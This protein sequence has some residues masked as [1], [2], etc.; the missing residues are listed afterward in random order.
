MKKQITKALMLVF[1]ASM[2]LPSYS[3]SQ[4]MR[5]WTW[6]PYKVKFKM[7]YNW[8]AKKSTG[9]VFIAKGPNDVTMKI[10]PLSY[11]RTAKKA[12]EYGMKTYS[13]VKSKRVQRRRYLR[14]AAGMT[15]YVIIGSGKSSRSRS[16]INFGVIGLKNSRTGKNLYVRFWWFKRQHSQMIR[17]LNKIAKSFKAM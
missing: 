4:S 5:N 8:K 12:A 6:R 9:Y 7:P 16:P 15:R 11:I 17:T 2:L 14:S 13:V 1:A 10:K 3:F